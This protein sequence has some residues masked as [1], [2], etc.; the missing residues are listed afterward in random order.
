MLPIDVQHL[1]TL[2]SLPF[3]GSH[4]DPFDRLIISQAISEDLL[5]VGSDREF[6]KYSKTPVGENLKVIWE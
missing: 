2:R 5:R 6:P 4:K 3:V 1:E